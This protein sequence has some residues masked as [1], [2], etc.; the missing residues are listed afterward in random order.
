MNY[1]TIKFDYDIAKMIERYQLEG[2]IF[3][4]GGAD[5]K[6]RNYVT[7]L[8]LSGSDKDYPVVVVLKNILTTWTEYACFSKTGVCKNYPIRL[9]IEYVSDENDYDDGTVFINPST[10][11][12]FVYNKSGK[13][14]TSYYVSYDP[15]LNKLNFSQFNNILDACGNLIERYV[16][17]SNDQRRKFAN[18]LLNDNSEVSKN[19]ISAFFKE[20]CSEEKSI[21]DVSNNVNK[22]NYDFKAFDQV[23]VRNSKTEKWKARF[24][25]MTENGKYGCT[26]SNFYNYCIPYTIMTKNYHGKTKDFNA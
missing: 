21:D 15:K 3:V 22:S 11:Y 8:T 23:L 10:S 9:Y 2:R 12:M 13:Y 6:E 18:A 24:F 5:G 7:I 1:K 17:A 20:F 4:Y 16:L 25:D 26:D 14:K 19:I